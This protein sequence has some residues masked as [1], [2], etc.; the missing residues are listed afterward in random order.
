MRILFADDQKDI[1]LLTKE[2]LENAGHNVVAV[3]N[4]EA[5][6]RA[7]REE[8]PFDLILL[9]EEMPGMTG[10]EVLRAIR[11]GEKSSGHIVAIAL[12]GYNTEQDEERLLKFGFDSVIGK[13]FR[14]ETLE[15]VIRASAPKSTSQARTAP[16]TDALTRLGGDE[17]LLRRVAR[18]V[19]RDLPV[20]LTKIQKAIQ[21]NKDDDLAS[22]AHALKGTLSI[23][24]ADK[25]TELCN[26]LQD[27]ASGRRFSEAAV[28]FAT[29]KD[30]IRQLEP[31]LKGYAGE[32]SGN[33]PG[34][35]KRSKS[36]RR[37]P[38]SKRKTP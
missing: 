18:T 8:A 32:R 11:A 28:T 4:G 9:D 13:P 27:Q 35:Q 19:L 6:L 29:L 21:R 34:T 15:T 24:G 5:A 10:S 37:N 30:A 2:Q 17:Q 16:P 36:N 33:G 14:M 23:F 26:E 31:N 1:R 20:R 3:A 38:E 25:A 12:T 22:L 7:L